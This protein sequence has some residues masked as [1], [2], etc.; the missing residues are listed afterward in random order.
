MPMNEHFQALLETKDLWLPALTWLLGQLSAT[1]N[2]IKIEEGIKGRLT[3]L[4]A[5]AR[6]GSLDPAETRPIFSNRR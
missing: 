1:G 4:K 3:W 2:G 5:P 6:R